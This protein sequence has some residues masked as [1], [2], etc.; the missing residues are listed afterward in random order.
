L[1]VS[2]QAQSSGEDRQGGQRQNGQE[3]RDQ[4][5]PRHREP[6]EIADRNEKGKQFE[7]L[8]SSLR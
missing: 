8:F 4:P 1:D 5:P 7:W 6:E 3:R 2:P